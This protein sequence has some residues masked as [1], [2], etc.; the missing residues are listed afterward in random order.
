MKKLFEIPKFNEA[1][2]SKQAEKQ[3]KFLKAVYPFL[4]DEE[5]WNEGAIELRPLQRSKDAKY[6]KSYNAWHI[7]EKDIDA[8]KKFLGMVNGKGYCLYF[9]G[10]AFDYQ[11]EVLKADGK[12]YQKGKINNENSLF[13]CI[14]PADFDGISYE[15]FEKE[16]QRLLDLGIET[17]DVFTGHGFQSHILLNHR[18]LDKDIFKKFTELLVAKGFKVDPA[19]V[20]SARILRMPYSFNCKSLDKNSKYYDA[21]FPEIMPT[22]DTSWTEKRY[23]MLEIFQKLQSLP[24]VIPETHAMTEIE[25]KAILTASLI[26][27]EKKKL[28][29]EIK[30]VGQIKIQ[31]L[32]DVY[33]MIDFEKL[34]E[35]IQKMLAGTQPHMRNQ[36]IMF[37]VPYL[38]NTLGLSLQTITQIMVKWAE[39]SKKDVEFVVS[40]VHR[41][42]GYGFKGKH[43]IYT[44]ELA[45]AYGYLEELSEYKRDNKIIIPNSIFKDFDAIVDGSVRIYLAMK[46]AEKINGVKEFTK[47][48]IQSIA[49]ISERTVERNMKDLVNG[50]HICKRRTNRRREEEYIFYISPYFSSVE[51]FTMLENAVAKM[52][53]NDLTDGEMKLYSYLCFIVGKESKNCWASQKYLSEKI[54]KSGHSVI[55]KMTDLLSQKGFITKKT[56]KQDE[57]MHSVYNLNY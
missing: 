54:G 10:F 23:H 25:I 3:I 20:D 39:L 18:V 41:I 9:S 11:K 16:K 19:I 55:S 24:D 15:E 5:N 42:Y 28:E 53:L 52:M 13:T 31:S 57:I 22:T 40:E 27:A 34:P 47:K 29:A 7:Q 44:S 30:E 1:Q 43:G 2:I 38:R 26:V 46:L 4:E 49:N 12:K 37:L 35:A 48:D 6:L 36:V 17:I 51:G 56:F 33:T 8:L 50:G 45:K 21:K 32:K 14:L